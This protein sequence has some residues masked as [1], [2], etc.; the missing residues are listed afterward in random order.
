MPRPGSRLIARTATAEGDQTAVT[1]ALR[2]IEIEQRLRQGGGRRGGEHYFGNQP[3][4]TDRDAIDF[5]LWLRKA[6]DLGIQFTDDDVRELARQEFYQT[7]T[8][9][10][11]AKAQS[12]VIARARPEVAQELLD[13]LGDEFRVRAAQGAVLG[14]AYL[15]PNARLFEAPVDFYRYYRQETA[16]GTFGVVNVPAADFVSRVTGEPTDAQLRE[17]FKKGEGEDP[18]PSSATIGLREPRRLKVEFTQITGDEPFYKKATEEAAKLVPLLTQVGGFFAGPRLALT[19]VP[20]AAN[21]GA[22]TNRAYAE[23]V[24]EH[25]RDVQTYWSGGGFGIVR[26][27]DTH[28]ATPASLAATVGIAGSSPLAAALVA[29]EGAIAADRKSRID[30][31]PPALFLPAANVGSNLVAVAAVVAPQI[32]ATQPLPKSAVQARLIKEAR[33]K[34]ATEV[35]TKDVT[36]FIG[37]MAKLAAKPGDPAARAKVAEF[38]KSRGLTAKASQQFR[39]VY[40]IHDD[41]GLSELAAKID[42]PRPFVPQ[43]TKGQQRQAFGFEMFFKSDPVTRRPLPDR[44]FFAPAPVGGQVALPVT[45]FWR[46]EEQPEERLRDF[47]LPATRAKL[48]AAWKRLEARKLAKAAA[49]DLAAKAQNLGTTSVE[50][51]QKLKDLQAKLEASLLNKTEPVRYFQLGDV[52]PITRQVVAGQDS[53]G[54]YSLPPSNDI[55]YPTYEMARQLLE[56]KE[57]PESTSVVLSDVPGDN[58]YVATLLYRIDPDAGQFATLVYGDVATAS[59]LAGPVRAAHQAE[60]RRELR[61][62]AVADLKAEY[63]YAKEMAGLDRVAE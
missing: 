48:V 58:Y 60:L 52:A 13:A 8:K 26:V 12:A 51:E 14:Q 46:T 19:Q 11:W 54:G 1:A 44:S 27:A 22:L 55:E 39:D 30:T 47:N 33:K 2:S 10:D 23:Y 34:L 40:S 5:R 21:P 31:L 62:T 43:L 57:K 38:I 18:R 59:R 37:E 29:V 32:V 53:V 24:A 15:R 6:S 9:D 50:I 4:L 20:I 7:L 63:G 41:P 56:A 25:D 16:P 42:V 61:D 17:L 49:E 28:L 36:K 3:A 35:A 45:L